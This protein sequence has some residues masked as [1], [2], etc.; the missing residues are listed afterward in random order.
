ME[1]NTK[2]VAIIGYGFVGKATEFFLDRFFPGTEIQIHDPAQGEDC[3][4]YTS[5][6]PRDG[7]LSRRPS[8]A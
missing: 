7:L 8:A 6:S 5:P 3:L 4:L 1:G 2:K